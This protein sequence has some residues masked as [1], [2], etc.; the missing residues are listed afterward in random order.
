MKDFFCFEISFPGIDFDKYMSKSTKTDIKHTAHLYSSKDE[1]ELR[2]FYESKTY[3][4]RKLSIWASQNWKD[5]GSSIKTSAENQNHRLKKID[6]S[7]SS[8]LKAVNGS[9]QFESNL[10]YISL[11]IDSIK[12][13]WAP[14]ESDQNSG[15]FYLDD[16][17]FNIVS[18]YYVPLLEFEDGFKIRRMYGMDE[19]YQIDMTE[20]RPEFEFPHWDKKD[21]R[22]IKIIKEPIIKFKYKKAITELEAYKYAEIV[23]LLSS[24]YLHAEVNYTFS[25][26]RLPQHTIIVKKIQNLKPPL[27][28]GGFE[29]FK[30]Y[31]N[32]D[33][34]MKWNWKLN[35]VKNFKKLSKVIDLFNQSFHVDENS[36]FLIRFNIIEIC[37]GG[38]KKVEEKFKSDL[39]NTEKNKIYKEASLLL[40]KTVREQDQKDF[41]EKLKVAKKNLAFKPKISPL[42]DFFEGQNLSPTTFPITVNEIKSIRDN[43]THGSLSKINQ[44]QLEK[45]NILLYRISGILIF[46]LLGID[47]WTLNINLE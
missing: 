16:N 35:V 25:R 2:I 11:I 7:D 19:F 31:W 23:R 38:I 17:G 5:F 39:S 18:E 9:K 26:I 43:L 28:S 22:E 45:A 46:N 36:K 8:L 3:F 34:F 41:L 6:F 1:I 40:L 24:F 21:N 15:E 20:F 47:Q 32:F 10:E 4:G 30:N 29:S 33:E 14:S 42:L 44:K 12:M 13:Y 27:Y 37:M